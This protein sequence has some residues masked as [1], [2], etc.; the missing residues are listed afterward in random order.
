MHDIT[1]YALYDTK[2][3]IYDTPLFFLKEEQA[4]RWFYTLVQ[5]KEGRFE[6]FKDDMELHRILKFN[7]TNGKVFEVKIIKILDGIQIGKE[8]QNHEKRN[9]TQV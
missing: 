3:E 4:K 9:D 8:I 5:K 2:A 1:A 6:Y 7:V